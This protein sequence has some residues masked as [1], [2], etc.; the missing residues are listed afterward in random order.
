[1]KGQVVDKVII[2]VVALVIIKIGPGTDPDFP[3]FYGTRI[4]AFLAEHHEL[5][6]QVFESLSTILLGVLWF[7]TVR[8]NNY[9][10]LQDTFK[11][12]KETLTPSRR[13]SHYAWCLLA[14]YG[15][16]L[17]F[18]IMGG[19]VF[20]GYIYVISLLIAWVGVYSAHKKF[21]TEHDTVT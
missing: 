14:A 5:Y 2:A 7:H 17:C 12:Y 16:N 18:A 19:P 11:E 3:D 20:I 6:N 9:R 13:Y 21:W 10:S 8:Q 15:P 4:G 1:M